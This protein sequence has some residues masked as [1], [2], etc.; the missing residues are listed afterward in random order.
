MH[1]YTLPW[2]RMPLHTEYTSTSVHIARGF[3][4]R[5][6]VWSFISFRFQF[7]HRLICILYYSHYYRFAVVVVIVSARDRRRRWLRMKCAC[8]PTT[9]YFYQSLLGIN[10]YSSLQCDAMDSDVSLTLSYSALDAS[11]LE[12]SFLHITQHTTQLNWIEWKRA[13]R[14]EYISFGKYF[15]PNLTLAMLSG[16]ADERGRVCVL[17]AVWFHEFAFWFLRR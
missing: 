6:R 10:V 8:I 5:I 7:C 2:R 13:H 17:C 11:V 1:T 9:I 12:A 15:R 3:S 16:E 4:H 14:S